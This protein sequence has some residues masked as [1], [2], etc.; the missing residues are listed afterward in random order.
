MERRTEK[1]KKKKRTANIKKLL[2]V[3]EVPEPA[4]LEAGEIFGE[5]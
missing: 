2:S 5:T 3:Q 4:L 1:I